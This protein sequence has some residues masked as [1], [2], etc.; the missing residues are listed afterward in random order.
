MVR[1]YFKRINEYLQL[2]IDRERKKLKVIGE[3]TNYKEQELPYTML[4]DKCEYHKLKAKEDFKDC[5]AC[6]MVILEQQS[7]TDKMHN[8]DFVMTFRSQ[9]QVYGFKLV[10]WENE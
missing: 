1:L 4:F 7:M 2:I 5:S 3:K 6:K 8:E 10:K 9:M